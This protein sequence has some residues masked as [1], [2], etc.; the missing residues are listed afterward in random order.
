VPLCVL[1]ASV[2]NLRRTLTTEA[3]RTHRDFQASPSE[4]RSV[5][6]SLQF[7]GVVQMFE[8][9]CDERAIL[10]DGWHEAMTN[11]AG[12]LLVTRRFAENYR[13][14]CDSRG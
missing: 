6:F 9:I 14:A 1:C 2:V 4:V 13:N 5:M 10:R 7:E 11:Y 8:L 3:Q 12:A